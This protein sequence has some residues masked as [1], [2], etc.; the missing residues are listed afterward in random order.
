MG[1]SESSVC[2]IDH[3]SGQRMNCTLCVQTIFSSESKN[4]VTDISISVI[5]IC[6]LIKKNLADNYF[7]ITIFFRPVKLQQFNNTYSGL[8][9]KTVKHNQIH[10]VLSFPVKINVVNY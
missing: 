2:A 4:C 8:C 3:S 5:Y 6:F 7:K 1:L 9:K 10:S